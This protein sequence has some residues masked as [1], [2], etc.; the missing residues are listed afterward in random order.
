MDYEKNGIPFVAHGPVD[1][2]VLTSTGVRNRS[3][4][5][6]VQDA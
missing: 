6:Q 1:L 5:V 4:L 2:K 3:Y